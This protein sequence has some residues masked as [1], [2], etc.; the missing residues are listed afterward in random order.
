M[1]SLLADVHGLELSPEV[2]PLP[3]EADGL[4]GLP[5]HHAPAALGGAPV[6]LAAQSEI[7]RQIQLQ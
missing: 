4:L 7:H 5:A 3:E 2:P 1:R 6:A